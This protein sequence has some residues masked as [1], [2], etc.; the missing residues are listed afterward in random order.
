MVLEL[1]SSPIKQQI[2]RTV[3]EQLE[4][5]GHSSAIAKIPS[6]LDAIYENIPENKR[7]SIGRYTTVKTLGEFLYDALIET[8]LAVCEIGAAICQSSQDHRGVGVGLSILSLYGLEDRERI[9]PIFETAA[10]SDHWELREFAQGFFRKVIKKHSQEIHDYL[11]NLAK[12]DDPNLRRFVSET[13]RPVVENQWLYTDIDYSLSVL[14][15]LFR[16]S[17]PYPRTSVGNNLSDIARR[18]PELVYGL[19]AELVAMRN[20][21]ASWIAT[22]ACR[23][24]VKKDPIRVMDIL[25]V[26]EY[27]YKDKVYKRHEFL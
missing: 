8:G 3:L 27:K 12:S 17:H 21:N 25:N 14:R 6:V 11:V 1:I 18:N 19:V 9:L 24:L 10:K 15:Y 16:E 2:N 20:K 13:L 26:D 22:R 7:I 23:N 4:S 5:G